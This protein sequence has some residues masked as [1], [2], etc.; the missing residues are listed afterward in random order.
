MGRGTGGWGRN[1]ITTSWMAG[2]NGAFNLL[3]NNMEL[4]GNYM[5]GGSQRY[6]EEQSSRTTYMDDG[7]VL[8]YDNDGYNTSTSDGHRFG[9]RLDHKFSENTSI[10]FEPQF[11]FGN[12][13]YTEY[14]DF[15]TLSE[16]NSVRDTTNRGFNENTGINRNWTANGFLLFRQRLGKPGRT[17]SVMF[18]Y[19]FSNNDLWGFN[20]SLTR[21]FENDAAVDDI[22]NQR[23]DQNSKSTS[24]TG[25]V[26][27]TEPLG[28][29]FYVEA[30]Y[31]YSWNR[32]TSI[33]DAYNSGGNASD[34][35]DSDGRHMTYDPSGEAY[36]GTYSNNILNRYI[37]QSAGLNF[38][39]QKDKLR[40]QLGAAIRPTDTHNETNGEN[41]DSKVINWSPQAMFGYD[42]DDNTNIRMFYFGRSSQPSTSQL[43]PV[44]DN[45]D[46]LNVS[47]GNPY[48]IPYFSHN[49]R[50]MFGYTDKN[51]FMSIH[52]RFGGSI[53][54]DPIVNAQWYDSNGAQY[55]I[56]VNGPTSGSVDGRV[57]INSPFGKNSKFSIFSMTYARYNES[58]SYIGKTDGFNTEDY[59]D[60]ETAEFNYDL[61]HKHF[62]ESRDEMFTENRTQS[63][64]F[65][66]RLRFTFRNDFLELNVGGRMRIS[67]SWYTIASYSQNA[68]WNNQIDASM[69]WTIPGGVNLIADCD[70]N[71]Y[72]GYTTPQD[73]EFVFN[74]EINKLLFKDKFTLAVKAY[75]I[76]NQSK[77]L[78]VTDESNYH[79]ETRNNTLGRYIMVS[80]TYRFGNFGQAGGGHRGPM[81][82]PHRR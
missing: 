80:L 8:I 39:Y 81:G 22:V 7:S 69:N 37:N 49:I 29:D 65:T 53:V 18:N 68:T 55:S 46:P 10:L 67:K 14:S 70:Y 41:Y 2:A 21:T 54:Q 25:R 76:F 43:M 38:M 59:Y 45:S 64:N 3:D 34:L 51:T 44:P 1:G 15:L 28:H 20:Q 13:S 11:N 56:P 48:L 52:G 19:N 77:N 6:V 33:K 32:S 73:D 66:Q 62:D 4:N 78:S 82:P 36:D 16:S 31:S 60:S 17:V 40:A 27:Y 26:V 30:N 79:L 12:G 74:A 58:A 47:L 23:Y 72:R 42:I 50:S 9:V 71:W 57:M 75:D 35:I 5:Y 24:M 61:F 63:L